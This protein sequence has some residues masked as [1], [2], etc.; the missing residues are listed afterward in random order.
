MA[1]HA[2]E[3][4]KMNAKTP[5]IQHLNDAQN[6]ASRIYSNE[7]IFLTYM[8]GIEDWLAK[9]PEKDNRNLKEA[10]DLLAFNVLQSALIAQDKPLLNYIEDKKLVSDNQSLY[11]VLN[12]TTKKDDLLA[13]IELDKTGLS[14]LNEQS[15]Q[16][17]IKS[18]EQ[19]NLVNSSLGSAISALV[20]LN[21]AIAN[22]K[23]GFTDQQ[24]LG[25]I[26]DQQTLGAIND[27]QTLGAINDQQALGAINDQQALGAI[28]DQQKLGVVYSQ[29]TLG[30]V[31]KDMQSLSSAMGDQQSL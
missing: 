30:N 10:H 3:N 27:Q 15:S 24:A 17:I 14:N 4:T 11:N 25:A 6:A 8:D 16:N 12:D 20:G 28:N 26:N 29:Q 5:I 22:L 1:L 21:D 13:F 19:L 9:Y 18:I 7:E 31:I 23:T 2:L